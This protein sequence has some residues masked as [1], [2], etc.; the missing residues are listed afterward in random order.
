MYKQVR[1]AIILRPYVYSSYS[2]NEQIYLYNILHK[3][4]E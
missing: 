4:F 1:L 3:T 2:G